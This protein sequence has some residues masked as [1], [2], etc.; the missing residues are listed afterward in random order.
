MILT[1]YAQAIGPGVVQLWVGMFGAADP[2][3]PSFELNE[4]NVVAVVVA[5]LRPIR[6]HASDAAGKPLNH[7]GIYR[8]PATAAGAFCRIVVRAGAERFALTIQSLPSEIPQSLD[9]T[10]NILLCSCY[11]QPEDAQGLLG[12]I[13]SQIQVRPHLTLMM[14]DQ[15]YGDLPLFENFPKDAGGIAQQLGTKYARNWISDQLGAGGLA[16]VLARSPVICVA[17]DHEFWNNFPYRQTQLPT[18]WTAEGREAW[19]T[20]AVELCED[21]QLPDRAGGIQRLDIDPLK[22]LVVDM[23]SLRDDTFNKLMSALTM[24]GIRTWVSDLIKSKQAGRPAF[25]LLCSGQAL[26]VSPQSDSKKRTVDAEMCN[27]TQFSDEFMPELEKLADAGIPIV[28]ITGDVHWGRVAQGFDVRTNRVLIHEVIASPSR[29]IG[30]PLVDSAKSFMNNVQGIFAAKDSWPRHSDAGKVPERL[31]GSNRYRLR[32]DLGSGGEGHAQRGDHVAIMSF[33][34]SGGG[35][36]FQVSYY[37]IT[38][39]KALAHSRTTRSFEL[40]TL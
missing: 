6:D 40:R 39:D 30:V 11:S 8:L 32:C 15:I 21:Y 27:Y 23:R 22:L 38:D 14:G 25:G 18:T 3:A 20:A 12:K 37:A 28:Y 7:R 36:D 16:P 9:G 19:R 33:A 4:A 26:F 5:P 13:V 17:D 10:F 24:D 29:L 34:R 35:V 31:G 2:P 1:A